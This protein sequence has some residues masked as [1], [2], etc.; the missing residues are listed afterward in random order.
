MTINDSGA[1]AKGAVS[2]NESSRG[3]VTYAPAQWTF[4]GPV[5]NP[6]CSVSAN[7]FVVSF[8]RVLAKTTSLSDAPYAVVALLLESCSVYVKPA[9]FAVSAINEGIQPVHSCHGLMGALTFV[10]SR[11]VMN[12]GSSVVTIAR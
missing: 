9:S 8:V 10:G 2:S 3:A 6:P 11:T 7:V 5:P 12:G 4:G 1:V